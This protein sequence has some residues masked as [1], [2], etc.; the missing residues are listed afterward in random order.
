MVSPVGNSASNQAFWDKL[1]ENSVQT[2]G[3]QM[4]QEQAQT[5]QEN[6]EL[7]RSSGSDVQTTTP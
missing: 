6:N 5:V 7:A 2:T 3:Q 1:E 4:Q